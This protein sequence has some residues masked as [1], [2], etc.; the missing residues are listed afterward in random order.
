VED[1]VTAEVAQ[2][3][4][5]LFTALSMGDVTWMEQ[6]VLFDDNAVHIGVGNAHWRNPR[7]LLEGLREQFA[8]EPMQWRVTAPVYLHRGDA[9]CVVDRPVISFDDGSELPCRVTLLFLHEGSW[10][11]AH[12]HLSV[13]S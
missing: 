11:L 3:V 4:G 10:K 7:E 2:L 13:G 12:T 9:V 5:A 8:L 6:H 1:P